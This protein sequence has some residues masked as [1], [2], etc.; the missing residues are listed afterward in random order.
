MFVATARYCIKVAA[1]KSCAGGLGDLQYSC[2]TSADVVSSHVMSCLSLLATKGV[3]LSLSFLKN[4]YIYI[5]QQSA[6]NSMTFF[7]C[8]GQFIRSLSYTVRVAA[9]VADLYLPG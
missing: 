3:N 5:Y 9:E 6:Y 1:K 4:P 2:R 8:T 7:V